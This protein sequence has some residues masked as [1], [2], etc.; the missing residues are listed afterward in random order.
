M[1][2]AFNVTTAYPLPSGAGCGRFFCG[3]QVFHACFPFCVIQR[4]PTA[5]FGAVGLFCRGGAA[6]GRVTSPATVGT[7]ARVRWA[8]CPPSVFG[9]Y[10]LPRFCR[11]VNPSGFGVPS[12]QGRAEGGV[13]PIDQTAV[14]CVLRRCALRGLRLVQL[15]GIRWAAVKAA[16][17]FQ[18][19][20]PPI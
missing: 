5:P 11:I 17:A 14:G 13:N 20:Q 1:N 12:P 8:I 19:L 18:P 2:S 16:S 7:T 3:S 10:S 9:T 15:P 6:N 4:S